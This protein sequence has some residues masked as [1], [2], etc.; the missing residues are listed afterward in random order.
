MSRLI[1]PEAVLSYPNLI[2]PRAAE[3]G[4]PPKYSCSLV[5]LEG[6][7]VTALKK[8]ALKVAQDRWGDKLKGAKIKVLETQYGPANFLVAEGIRIRLPWRDAPKDVANKGYPAG[9]TFVNANT[10]R[11]PQIVTLI[12]NPPGHPKE[13]QPSVL[14]DESKV[15]GPGA[16]VR[17]SLDP[18]AYSN[19]GNN[20][21][22]FGLG[23][24]Q[25]IRDG[26]A[27]LIGASSGPPATDEFDA[28]A[29]AV[30]DLADL[31][32]D[33]ATGGDALDDLIGG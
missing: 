9:S 22:T 10:Q 4:K 16:I 32:A 2:T 27:S 17:A 29:D 5:F 13:G 24:I 31:G 33:E 6:T 15:S 25:Y 23:N 8:A 28:D 20:G 14:T 21:V 3:E 19:S 12:P 7:D 1:T 11:K 18:Y 30:A 26:D